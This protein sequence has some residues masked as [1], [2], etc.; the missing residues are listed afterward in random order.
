MDIST[1]TKPV[2]SKAE[3]MMAESNMMADRDE[4]FNTRYGSYR[5]WQMAI[6]R[7]KPIPRDTAQLDLDRDGAGARLQDHAPKWS[8]T[9]GHRFL[10]VP[11]DA[12]HAAEAGSIFST[13]ELG[14]DR[15]RAAPKPTWKIR[16][17]CCCT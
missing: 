5:G 10:R 13:R 9:S 11:L 12:R 14:T 17:G 6:E 16:C 8:T 4:D 2:G 7:V 15:H 3:T 1:A